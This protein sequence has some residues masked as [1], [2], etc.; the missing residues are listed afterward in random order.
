MDKPKRQPQ[1]EQLQ[2]QPDYEL[3]FEHVIVEDKPKGKPKPK[4]QPAR[5]R[6][7]ALAF[8]L[9]AVI[10]IVVSGLAIRGAL[11]RSPA[12]LTPAN[13]LSNAD[14]A[15]L[16]G[17]ASRALPLGWVDV[18]V[19]SQRIVWSPDGKTLAVSGE[20]SPLQVYQAANL[21]A[22]PLTLKTAANVRLIAF[23]PDSRRIAGLLGARQG[24]AVWDTATGEQVATADYPEDAAAALA[25]TPQGDIV[26]LGW[27]TRLIFRWDMRGEPQRIGLTDAPNTIWSL[28][29]SPDG[30]RIAGSDDASHLWLWNAETGLA[31]HRW[32]GESDGNATVVAFSPDGKVLSSGDVWGFVKTWNVERQNNLFG[33]KFHTAGVTT[34]AFSPDGAFLASGVGGYSPAPSVDDSVRLWRWNTQTTQQYVDVLRGHRLPVYGIAFNPD[35]ARLAVLLQGTPEDQTVP[36]AHLWLWDIHMLSGATA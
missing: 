25:F 10:L 12:N 23:S 3:G 16:I 4:H 31:L 35:G 1:P 26:A 24:I 8:L 36:Q 14:Q 27:G 2:A 15:V 18:P 6:R 5:R 13:R 17:S 19:G 11:V 28:A 34:L 21:E 29:I 20:P 9:A 33:N 32:F 22:P 30:K 7:F